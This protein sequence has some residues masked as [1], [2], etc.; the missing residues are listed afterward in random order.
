MVRNTGR[1]MRMTKCR[2]RDVED[3]K[4]RKDRDMMM[5][6]NMKIDMWRMRRNQKTKPIMRRN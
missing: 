6:I 5:I 3:D 1:R 4:K 2:A